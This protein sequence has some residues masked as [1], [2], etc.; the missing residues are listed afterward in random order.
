MRILLQMA[1]LASLV[2]GGIAAAQDCELELVLAMD[3]SR[4]VNPAEFDLIRGG[5]A[6][7]FRDPSI[8]EIIGWLNGGLMITATQWSS[9]AEQ[10]Q[11][12][13]WRLLNSPQSVRDFADEVDEMKRAFRFDLTAPGDALLFAEALGKSNPLKC[14]RRVIDISGDGIKNAGQ[15]VAPIATEIAR[16]GVTINGLV[17]RGDRPDPLEFYENEIK[18]GPLSFIEIADGFEDFPRAILKKLLRELPPSLSSIPGSGH[19]VRPL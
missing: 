6:S 17:V 19:D 5:T 7:A 12:M 10:M 13:P 14:R 18:R 16:K 15:T 4:S 11:M 9:S 1:T 2:W 3:V 8:I